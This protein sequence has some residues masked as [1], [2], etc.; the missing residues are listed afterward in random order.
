MNPK[1]FKKNHKKAW[2]IGALSF[3]GFSVVAIS[4]GCSL[5]SN[6][7]SDFPMRQNHVTNTV[8]QNTLY[9]DIHDLTF[10]LFFRNSVEFDRSHVS[11]VR[12]TGWL[13]DYS[14]T[15]NPSNNSLSSFTA[16]IATNLHVANNLLNP[17]DNPEYLAPA[18]DKNSSSFDPS[19]SKTL[20]FAFSKFEENNP[21]IVDFPASHLP[22][23]QYA[24]INLNDGTTYTT[25]V[26][27]TDGSSVNQNLKAYLDFAVLKYTISF[28][29]F[30]T[31]QSAKDQ[32]IYDDLF[33]PAV[34]TLDK[35]TADKS[36]FSSVDYTRGALA[37]TRAFIAGYPA[38]SSVGNV[39]TWTI[40]SNAGS[41]SISLGQPVNT[42]R[43]F[44]F[45]SNSPVPGMQ[46]NTLNPKFTLTYHGTTYRKYGVSYFIN[47]S[48]LGE[49]SSGSMMMNQDG[50]VM[51]IYFGTVQPVGDT[52]PIG[53]G[54]ADALY[55]NTHDLAR[56]KNAGINSYNLITDP[57]DSYLASL[58]ADNIQTNFFNK[59]STTTP[60]N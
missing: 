22:M 7:P 30:G 17:N 51:G 19:A 32:A 35:L 6:P 42:S 31:P 3:S 28:N 26:K 5:F 16:Y 11:L 21:K 59:T 24:A 18:F 39:P 2:L 36:F 23:T 10:S 55:L 44:T 8:P 57:K 38:D 27:Q 43:D 54:F 47:D 33:L 1:S 15:V 37:T 14:E 58:Q 52:T 29:R 40:N 49:G 53:F 12:G 60:Q 13:F 50:Q 25:P 34:S 4:T 45:D 9:E 48:N 20:E 41:N 46:I 56:F